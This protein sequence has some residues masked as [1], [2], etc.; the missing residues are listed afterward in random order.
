MTKKEIKKKIEDS[1]SLANML[2][3]AMGGHME[4][5]RIVSTSLIDG[6]HVAYVYNLK[7]NRLEFHMKNTDEHCATGIQSKDVPEKLSE[8]LSRTDFIIRKYTWL[9]E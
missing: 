7:E 6:G 2:N 8:I 1:F 9:G 3:T 5:F 4:S